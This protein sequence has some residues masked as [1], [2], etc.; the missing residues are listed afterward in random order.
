M[1]ELDSPSRFETPSK[2]VSTLASDTI[3]ESSLPR[4]PLNKVNS[5]KKQ[6]KF[7]S[8]NVSPSNFK[9]RE[10]ISF[11]LSSK[12]YY[13]LEQSRFHGLSP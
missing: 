9:G 12:K 4:I 10:S 2:K 5:P 11:D 13:N 6:N 7:Y 1:Q 8:Q 3:Q